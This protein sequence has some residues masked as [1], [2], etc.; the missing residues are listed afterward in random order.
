MT[1][2]V[3]LYAFTL[4]IFCRFSHSIPLPDNNST[5]FI[6]TV[7]VAQVELTV[8]QA[9]ALATALNAVDTL[10]F[11]PP[12]IPPPSNSSPPSSVAGDIDSLNLYPS[13]SP[14]VTI[15][16]QSAASLSQPPETLVTTTAVEILTDTETVTRP[17][18]TITVSAAPST[19]TDVVTVFIPISLP[20]PSS[21]PTPSGSKTAWTAPAQMTDLSAFNISAF[22]GGQQNL[23]LVNGIPADASAASLFDSAV[24]PSGA[25]SPDTG[26]DNATTVLQLLYPANSINPGSKP[27]GGAEFY[28]TPLSLAHAENVSLNYSVFFPGDFDWVKAGKLP[29]LYGGHTGCSGGAA[30][31]DCF[32]TRLMWREDGAGEL[33]LYA[34]KDKQ[35]DALCSDPQSVCDAAYGFSIGRDSFTFAAGGWTTVLQTVQLNT[36]GKQDGRFSLDVNGQRVIHRDDVFYRDV[37]PPPSGGAGAKT[38]KAK[39]PPKPSST[40]TSGDDGDGGGVLGPLLTGLL[41]RRTAVQG[42]PRDMRPLL[43]PVQTAGLEQSSAAMVTFLVDTGTYHEAVQLAPALPGTVTTTLSATDITTTSTVWVTS[44]VYPSPSI[45]ELAAQHGPVGFLGIFFSTFFG[46]HEADYATPKDQYV[47]FKDFGLTTHNS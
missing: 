16:S 17:P 10:L 38:S 40:S 12:Q 25:T 24:E 39:V 4:C 22:P 42:V 3:L 37:V 15:S 20:P 27:Q 8:I 19:V 2:T 30:A 44:I 5:T 9:S 43:L 13:F 1:L 46:G 35:T 18:T 45:S 31:L 33:Y 26:W 32:S 47:W 28:A 36:P 21:T 41:G 23:R 34:P 14:P 6:S 29:G 11:G 7:S